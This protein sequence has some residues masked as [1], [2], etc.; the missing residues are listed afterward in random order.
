MDIDRK[1]QISAVCHAH[2][3][4]HTEAEDVYFKAADLAFNDRVLDTYR[5]EAIKLGANERQIKGI[6]LLK[7]RVARYKKDHPDRIKVPDIDEGREEQIVN[8]PNE[9]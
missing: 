2:G 4:L 8:R 5:E 3:H 6:E 9:S 7:E 1:F